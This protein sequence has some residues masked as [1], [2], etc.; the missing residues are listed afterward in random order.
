MHNLHIMHN[1]R[2]YTQEEKYRQIIQHSYTVFNAFLLTKMCESKGYS[3][4]CIVNA[5]WPI[6]ISEVPVI[7]KASLSRKHLQNMLLVLFFM[8]KWKISDKE[9]NQIAI[10]YI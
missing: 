4:S 8:S 10:L 6:Q 9:E 5:D 1:L 2:I 3:F 7:C